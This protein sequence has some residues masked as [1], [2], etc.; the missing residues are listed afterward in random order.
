MKT[1]KSNEMIC[2]EVHI[3]IQPKKGLTRHADLQEY[4]TGRLLKFADT[5][6]NG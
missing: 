6:R 5:E 1:R 2:R 4:M 3:Y